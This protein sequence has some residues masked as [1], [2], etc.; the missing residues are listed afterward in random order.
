M[1]WSTDL[2][3]VW[4]MCEFLS[5]SASC[6]VYMNYSMCREAGGNIS[7]DHNGSNNFSGRSRA[8]CLDNKDLE[9]MFRQMNN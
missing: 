8:K 4:F 6:F 7:I 1:T 5:G 3:C 2:I 9:E